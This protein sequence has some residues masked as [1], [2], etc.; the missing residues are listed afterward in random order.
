MGS[1]RTN[2]RVKVFFCGDRGPQ[3]VG[4]GARAG[5][6]R[7]TGRVVTAPGF[8]KAWVRAKPQ[9]LKAMGG[10]EALNSKTSEWL[11]NFRPVL[12][13]DPIR[14]EWLRNRIL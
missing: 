5:R 1:E 12:N 11:R 3:A 8:Q 10:C 9:T 2:G 6:P 13:P 4:R 7:A 14:S